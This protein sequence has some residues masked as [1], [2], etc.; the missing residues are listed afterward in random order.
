MNRK[1]AIAY[2]G[3]ATVTILCG[4]L[5]TGILLA[6]APAAPDAPEADVTPRT[7]EV[8]EDSTKP[9]SNAVRERETSGNPLWA[10][11]LASL[12]ATR[13]R[14]IFSPSRRPPAP[15]AE[16]PRASPVARS[17]APPAEPGRPKLALV[18]TVIGDTQSIAVFTDTMTSNTVRL[19]PGEG[20]AGWILLS[21]EGRE[22]ALQKDSETAILALPPRGSGA[23]IDAAGIL[24]VPPLRIPLPV[25]LPVIP[26]ARH[27]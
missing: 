24:P 1:R 25:F 12:T 17:A 8:G 3:L 22:A 5:G 11:S 16:P 18:A 7:M 20:H 9:P 10:T 19:R 26:P 15:P 14:P 4:V 13:E 27:Q 21:V 2:L 23:S 6:Y